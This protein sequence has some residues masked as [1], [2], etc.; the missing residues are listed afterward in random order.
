MTNKS[1]T[2]IA[3]DPANLIK[4]KIKA[5]EL[6]YQAKLQNSDEEDCAAV[7]DARDH[8]TRS[9]SRCLNNP[10][11][12]ESTLLE[13]LHAQEYIGVRIASEETHSLD[14]YDCKD[15]I[16]F[17]FMLGFSIAGFLALGSIGIVGFV[18]AS[19]FIAFF[20]LG[21]LCGLCYNILC[22]TPKMHTIRKEERDLF[23][24]FRQP[25][26]RKTIP[27]DIIKTVEEQLAASFQPEQIGLV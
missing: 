12:I 16:A 2:I 6:L 20:A 22:T 13:Y 7:I 8:F 18:S 3:R 14:Y 19:P 24:M 9:L 26:T 15:E 10:E 25:E 23:R 5:F 27:K 17:Y 21:F 1:K 4:Q 11:M